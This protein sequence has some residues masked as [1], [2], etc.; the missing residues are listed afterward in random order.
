V[1]TRKSKPNRP[2]PRGPAKA[3]RRRGHGDEDS[4]LARTAQE[5]MEQPHLRPVENKKLA[6]LEN[7]FLRAWKK[8]YENR[9]KRRSGPWKALAQVRRFIPSQSFARESI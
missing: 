3:K 8:T 1:A 9:N 6:K 2:S 7:L 5:S 4:L